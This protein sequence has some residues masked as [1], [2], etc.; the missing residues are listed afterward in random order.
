MLDRAFS[1]KL[2]DIRIAVSRDGTTETIDIPAANAYTR[3]V[4]HFGRAVAGTEPLRYGRDDA[5]GTAR[6]I[7][8]AFASERSGRPEAGA[9]ASLSTESPTTS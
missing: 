3:M 4:E 2:L 9:P 8:A 6:T 5:L 1:A 7:D